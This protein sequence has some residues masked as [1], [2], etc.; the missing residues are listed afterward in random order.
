MPWRCPSWVSSVGWDEASPGSAC[1]SPPLSDKA[2]PTDFS[3]LNCEWTMP[4]VQAPPVRSVM[5][6]GNESCVPC[7]Q[8]SCCMCPGLKPLLAAKDKTAPGGRWDFGLLVSLCHTASS[9]HSLLQVVAEFH[10][11]LMLSEPQKQGLYQS[12]FIFV[13]RFEE[14]LQYQPFK[15]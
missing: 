8:S 5:A 6:V 9:P 10:L 14:V 1:F 13:A 12:K 4:G 2:Q 15:K 7:P 11:G 3:Y